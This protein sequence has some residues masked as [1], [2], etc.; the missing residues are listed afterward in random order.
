[1]IDRLSC[2]VGISVRST[3][4]L[5]HKDLQLR[6]KC[7]KL[8]PHVLTERQKM[9]RRR[10]CEDFLRRCRCQ[11]FHRW[12]IT[13]DEVW[14]Y[15]HEPGSRTENKQWITSQENQP[16]VPQHERNCKKMMIIPFFN[17]CGLLD[18][19]YFENKNINQR[20]FEPVI[21]EVWDVVHNRRGRAVWQQRH[22]LHLHM[23]NALAHH[24]T[25]VQCALQEMEWRQIP[26]PP[27]YSP[28]LS[29]CDFF[30]SHI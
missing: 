26:H 14:F 7:A 22:K 23:D 20:T 17:G 21:R 27:P 6:K 1:M 9:Q 18:I 24:G 25:N 19:H 8:I 4:R 5:L 12:V 28:D 3:H 16:Q 29:P 30:C 2:S 11:N 15:L 10:F 13:T